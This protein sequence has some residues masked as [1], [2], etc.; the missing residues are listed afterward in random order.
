MG[1]ILTGKAPRAIARII[2]GADIQTGGCRRRMS[3]RGC[4]IRL[5][6]ISL[7]VEMRLI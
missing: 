5:K 6:V 1:L 4:M 3:W 2:E 7:P